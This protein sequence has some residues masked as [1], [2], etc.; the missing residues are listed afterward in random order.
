MLAQLHPRAG[1][2]GR[3]EELTAAL[4]VGLRHKLSLK[5]MVSND[6]H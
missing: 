6:F 2:G 1:I 4:P 5:S 3:N